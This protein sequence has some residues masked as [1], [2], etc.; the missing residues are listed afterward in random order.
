MCAALGVEFLD[1][2]DDV[3]L[4]RGEVVGACTAPVRGALLLGHVTGLAVEQSCRSTVYADRTS[5]IS[6][7]STQRVSCVHAVSV[8][9]RS[10]AKPTL[11]ASTTSTL[12]S[13][14][15]STVSKQ[16]ATASK[17]KLCAVST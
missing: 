1:V 4:A 3:E 14:F 7:V 12:C 15:V 8:E 11:D 13:V 9:S 17:S 10:S 2:N 16:G 5:R 6:A